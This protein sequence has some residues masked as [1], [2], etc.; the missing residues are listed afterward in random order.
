MRKPPASVPLAAMLVPMVVAIGMMLFGGALYTMRLFSVSTGP[1]S[2]TVGR[3]FP[4]VAMGYGTLVL[5][6][7]AIVEVR[8]YLLRV[9]E[10][11]HRERRLQ[12]AVEELDREEDRERESV[13]A[14][15]HDD[16]GGGLTALRMELEMA[17]ARPKDQAVWERCYAKLDALLS[18]VRGVARTF[19]PR[20]VGSLGLSAVLREMAD[21]LGA[22]GKMETEFDFDGPVDAL[23]ETR[24]LCVLKVV[25]EAFV[26]VLRHSNGKKVRVT[27]RVRD[28]LARGSVLDDGTGR[29]EIHEGLGTTLMRERLR[30]LGGSLQLRLSPQGGMQVGFELPA[31]TEGEGKGA[32]A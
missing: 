31:E 6:A 5:L 23:P 20:L 26:N 24:A 3:F 22:G 4:M 15:L 1:L 10:L 12:Q 8:F 29:R 30:A 9:R 21:R 11:E 28:G 16:I 18:Q 25:Q 32:S 2:E 13:S 27:L 17:E 7:V 14:A 19:Y